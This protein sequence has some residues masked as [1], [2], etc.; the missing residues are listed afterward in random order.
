MAQGGYQ[1]LAKQVMSNGGSMQDAGRLWQAAG[2]NLQRAQQ[3]LRK[4][5]NNKRNMRGGAEE[6][7]ALKLDD[8]G[9]TTEFDEK[10]GEAGMDSSEADLNA[11][12]DSPKVEE[13]DASDPAVPDGFGSMFGGKRRRNSR[14]NNNKRN[15]RGGSDAEKLNDGGATTEFDEKSGEAGMDSGEADLNAASDSPKVEE[16]DAPDVSKMMSAMTSMLG[17]KRRS[18]KKRNNNRKGGNRQSQK[19]RNN[20]NRKGGKKQQQQQSRK[21]GKKQQQQS[22]KGGKNNRRN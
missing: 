3:M 2:K 8:G 4:G 18:Q 1:Q 19:K 5:G 22:R 15:M 12:S 6:D 16:Q 7:S 14:K 9:A 17:G 10:S 11:A 21:G 20:N 13:K